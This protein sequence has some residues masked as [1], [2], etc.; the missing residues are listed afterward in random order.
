MACKILYE[1]FP[2]YSVVSFCL[3]FTVNW[4]KLP[5]RHPANCCLS[6][7]KVQ[8]NHCPLNAFMT[9]LSSASFTCSVLSWQCDFNLYHRNILLY[10]IASFLSCSRIWGQVHSFVSL[11]PATPRNV[12]IQ[13]L[14]ASLL[15]DYNSLVNS[16]IYCGLRVRCKQI[17]ALVILSYS[18][19]I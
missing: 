9:L 8:F 12:S 14:N 13:S 16:V 19:F 18:L 2:V 5:I 3:P 11:D 10:L 4:G 7:I 17:E 6:F 15:S 1:L